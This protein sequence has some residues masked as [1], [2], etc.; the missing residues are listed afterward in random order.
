MHVFALL[1]PPGSN[2]EERN[3][4]ILGAINGVKLLLVVLRLDADHLQGKYPGV[5]WSDLRVSQMT[6]KHEL[7]AQPVHS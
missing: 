7:A 2:E 1:A 3:G 5:D 4:Q 6:T